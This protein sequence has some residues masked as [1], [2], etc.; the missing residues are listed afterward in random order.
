MEREKVLDKVR[1][2]MAKAADPCNVHEAAASAEAAQRL[3]LLHK[4]EEAEIGCEPQDEDPITDI[5][6]LADSQQKAPT[7]WQRILL[8]AVS[9]SCSCKLVVIPGGNGRKGR[10]RVF[11]RGSDLDAVRYLYQALTRQIND[12]CE[13]WANSQS[14]YVERSDR[15]GFRYGAACTIQGRL[16]SAR[17]SQEKEFARD[18]GTTALV[19][20]RLAEEDVAAHIREQVGRTTAHYH[21]APSSRYGYEAGKV[22]GLHIHLGAASGALGPG[23]H[24]LPHG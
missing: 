4:I 21:Q 9:Y 14:Y 2:L 15:N 18:R 17:H 5:D 10:L 13:M 6:L 7:T 20:L 23:Q 8:N 12:L 3:M 1:K 24:R 22:A 16:N 19:P 11:G